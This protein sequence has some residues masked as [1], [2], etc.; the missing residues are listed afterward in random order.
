[1]TADGVTDDRL[2]A[3]PVEPAGAD[4]AGIGLPTPVG[5]L[6]TGA[7]RAPVFRLLRSELRWV[8]RRPRTLILLGLFALVP[9][10]AGI[11]IVIA[12]SNSAP[13]NGGDDDGGLL[14]FVAGN[15]L[16]LPIATLVLA[17]NLM[18]PLAAA[19]A[20]A[21]AI[22]GETN[23]GTLRG[24][25]LAPVSR[26]R[27]LAVKAFGV[28]VVAATAT[29]VMAVV[30]LITGLIISGSDNLLTLS[31]STVSFG[32]ALGRIAL[33]VAWVTLQLCGVAAIALAIS[34][35]TE[36]PL[37]VVAV[38][39][40]GLIFFT[41]LGAIPAL[42]WLQPFLL[43]TSWP[44]VGDVLRDPIPSDGLLEGVWRALAYIA[45]GYSAALARLASKEG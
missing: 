26:V 31:G 22:A 21:D 11:G 29:A 25:L 42:D 3:R 7:R 14:T 33:A 1:M 32:S 15:G 43:T 13:T 24:L 17:L 44:S 2:P 18:L 28:L 39:L 34:T 40:G 36:H 35:M 37:V 20:G 27:L 19:V 9:I 4:R 6:R 30:G 41:V 8:Y 5:T 45:I 10:I 38:T 12:D 23:S 16:V